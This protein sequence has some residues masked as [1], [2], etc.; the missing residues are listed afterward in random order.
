VCSESS[1]CQLNGVYL[2]YQP[3][4]NAS[5]LEKILLCSGQKD[6]EGH[7]AS[8][9]TTA[10]SALTK[11]VIN[12]CDIINID[13]SRLAD[14]FPRLENLC[15]RP[16]YKPV[17]LTKGPLYTNMRVLELD[18]VA[19]HSFKRID[20][21]CMPNL[22]EL[23]IR[24]SDDFHSLIRIDSFPHFPR[25]TKLKLILEQVMWIHPRA[26]DHLTQLTRFEI[27]SEHLRSD[28][29]ETGVAARFMRFYINCQVLK[30]SS[31]S[32]S[33]A[34][35]I[36]LIYYGTRLE[37]LVALSGLKKLT[38]SECAVPDLKFHQMTNLEYV[39]LV[40]SDLSITSSGQLKCLSKLKVLE[41]KYAN[42]NTNK[43]KCFF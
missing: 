19:M 21:S 43:S 27:Y 30:L 42:R 22:E 11:L 2:S 8:T 17:I 24:F 36:E 37:T 29:F 9:R 38:A 14:Y 20:G 10:L 16:G 12:K 15:I 41:V 7:I 28:T 39:S 6:L 34:E 35:E 32:V 26:F 4:D 18:R 31:S 25:L 40:A 3:T 5:C 33:N 13:M 23:F 1:P